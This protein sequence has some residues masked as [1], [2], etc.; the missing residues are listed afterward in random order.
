MIVLGIRGAVYAPGNE[1]YIG[2]RLKTI[3]FL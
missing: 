3:L 1:T 2:L